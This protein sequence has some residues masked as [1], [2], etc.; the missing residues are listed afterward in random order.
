MPGF[1]QGYERS[2]ASA[3]AILEFLE[4]YFDID[5]T[6]KQAILSRLEAHSTELNLFHSCAETGEQLL[7]HRR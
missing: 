4:K 5:K 1:M 6:I 7:E 3:R 2:P